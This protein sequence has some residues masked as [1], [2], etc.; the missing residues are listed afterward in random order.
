MY[1]FPSVVVSFECRSAE[2]EAG[3]SI[4]R[5]V[6]VEETKGT[7]FLEAWRSL[8]GSQVISLSSSVFVIL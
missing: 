7:G 3:F 4:L 2:M 6:G 8:V 5:G 1:D